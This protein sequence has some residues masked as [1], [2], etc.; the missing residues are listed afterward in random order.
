MRRSARSGRGIYSGMKPD[1][2]RALALLD[3]CLLDA[4]GGRRPAR[5]A[6]EALVDALLG[7]E[8]APPRAVAEEIG[9]S[10]RVPGV[11]LWGVRFRDGSGHFWRWLPFVG[12]EAFARALAEQRQRDWDAAPGKRAACGVRTYQPCEVAPNWDEVEGEFRV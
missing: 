5:A 6:V 10:P 12:E 4:S 8:D 7:R 2:S 11:S 9:L 1:R 3:A